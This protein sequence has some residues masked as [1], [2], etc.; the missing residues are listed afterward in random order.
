MDFPAGVSFYTG[1]A[2]LARRSLEEKIISILAREGFEEVITPV[3]EYCKDSGD[4]EGGEKAYRFPDQQTGRMLALRSDFTLQIAHLAATRMKRGGGGFRWCYRGNVFRPIK[5]H[6]GQKR[7]IYQ[8]GAELLGDASLDTTVRMIDLAV[9]ILLAAGLADFNLVIG[10]VGFV[11]KL[12][13]L[14]DLPPGE[15]PD[16]REI[17]RRKDLSG[18]E[19]MAR[20]INLSA[21]RVEAVRKSMYLL[22]GEETLEEAGQIFVDPETTDVMEELRGV[23][24]KTVNAGGH[25]LFDLTEPRGF[26]YYTGIMFQIVVPKI[27]EEVCKGGRYDNLLDIYGCPTPAVG[28]AADLDLLLQAAEGHE[29]EKNNGQY[30]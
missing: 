9:E 14:L 16:I 19:K 21:D 29:Q 3:L 30:K 24:D 6:A 26:D 25:I 11:E 22:G 7:Q 23:L 27:G 5:E 18:L 4:R 28:F 2:S 10:H 8:I 13:G 20:R 15:E 1:D 12:M 17:L